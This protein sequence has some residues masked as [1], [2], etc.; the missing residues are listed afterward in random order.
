MQEQKAKPGS[1]KAEW[2]PSPPNSPST[3]P[4]SWALTGSALV[5]GEAMEETWK[6]AQS[7]DRE[8]YLYLWALEDK[9]LS[10]E[11]QNARPLP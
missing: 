1:I 7:A 3:Q 6:L 2:E 8:A 11:I 9:K 10:L 4:W 5:K